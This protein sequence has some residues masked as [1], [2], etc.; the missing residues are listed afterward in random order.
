[1]SKRYYLIAQYYPQ[2]GETETNPACL[3]GASGSY[4][5]SFP[6]AEKLKA[7][8][9]YTSK[10]RADRYAMKCNGN[11]MYSRFAVVDVTDMV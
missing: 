7:A 9:C 3:F 5:V 2:H 4:V 11:H 10:A 1:M 8:F 6:P